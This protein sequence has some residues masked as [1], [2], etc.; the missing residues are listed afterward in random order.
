MFVAAVQT[1][2]PPFF[3]LDGDQQSEVVLRLKEG[4]E[5]PVGTLVY[6]VR[7]SDPDADPLQFAL[8]GSAANELLAIEPV[9]ATHANLVLKKLLDREVQDE[10]SFVLT[11]TDGRSGLADSIK[12]SLLILVEDVNDNEPVFQPFPNT[13]FVQENG[14]PDVILTLEATDRDQGAYGQV[15]YSLEGQDNVPFAIATVGGQGILRTLTSLDYEQNSLYQ[16]RILAKDR[17]SEGRVNTATAALLIRVV[18]VE[19]QD[20]EFIAFPSIT[21]VSE[22]TQPGT[23]IMKGKSLM[24]DTYRLVRTGGT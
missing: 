4:S 1:N 2:Q 23:I 15:V 22:D 10:Y 20:P 17:A 19:D 18:D 24:S 12:L 9:D 5:T 11:L 3:E 14:D 8:Q 13:I 6:Q 21:R 7:A 16:L